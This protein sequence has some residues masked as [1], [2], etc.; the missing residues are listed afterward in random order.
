MVGF[1]SCP[2]LFDRI[3]NLL[4]EM[5]LV[6]RMLAT[7]LLAQNAVRYLNRLRI[8]HDGTVILKT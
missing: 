6:V 4:S 1:N 2:K 3:A 8:P 7:G 5:H